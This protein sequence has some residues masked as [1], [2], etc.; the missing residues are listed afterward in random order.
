[1]VTILGDG[2]TCASLQDRLS[3][4][5]HGVPPASRESGITFQVGMTDRGLEVSGTAWGHQLLPWGQVEPGLSDMGPSGSFPL[6]VQRCHTGSLKLP[7]WEYLRHRDGQMLRLNSASQ[8]V[9]SIRVG[10]CHELTYTP[11]RAREWTVGGV[12]LGRLASRLEP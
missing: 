12:K 7:R 5:P 3:M 4:L 9:F 1:M 2:H 6:H 10:D 11:P 8:S